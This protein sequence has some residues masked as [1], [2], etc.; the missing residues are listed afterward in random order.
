MNT[1]V[2]N[3]DDQAAILADFADWS[4]GFTPDECDREQVERYVRTSLSAKF[5]AAA[6][7]E[8]LTRAC[9]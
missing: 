2:L 6:A 7:T 3:A 5:D 4:G 1:T 9:K 8:F